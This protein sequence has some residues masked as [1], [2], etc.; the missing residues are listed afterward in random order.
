M[1]RIP[2]KAGARGSLKWIQRAVN[3]RPELLDE[4]LRARIG[5]GPISWLSPR[6]EDGYAEYRDGD[7]LDLLGAGD[8]RTDLADF[9][10]A[11]GPQ[12]DALGRS[13]RGDLLLV[14]AKAHVPEMLSPASAASPASL[15]RIRDALGRTAESLG[16]TP[17]AAWTDAFYQYANRL[18]HLAFFRDRGRPAWLV[19]VSFVGDAEM[20]GPRTAEAWDAAYTVA[21]YAMGLR[22]DHRLSR[23]I[24]HLHPDVRDLG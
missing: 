24:I 17:R 12:W 21:D 8:L 11:R 16:A 23:Y 22:A 6:R 18:A 15:A 3:D 5:H 7:F 4:P 2:C 14:E 19:L 1:S 9:W 10:P 20:K 13:E